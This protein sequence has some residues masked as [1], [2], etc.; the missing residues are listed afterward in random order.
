MLTS[1][2]KKV[3]TTDINENIRVVKAI[4]YVDYG[5]SEHKQH[6]L[7]LTF[8]DNSTV[9]SVH[10]CRNSRSNTLIMK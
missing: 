7:G 9:V 8:Y 5:S 10:Y 2:E 6:P 4:V 3:I 1:N